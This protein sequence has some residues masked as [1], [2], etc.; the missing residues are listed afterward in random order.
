MQQQQQE[1]VKEEKVVV[2][3]LAERDRPLLAQSRY[4]RRG[5][6]TINQV[7]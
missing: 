2:V 1:E 5:N 4:S 7:V 3:V 6:Q